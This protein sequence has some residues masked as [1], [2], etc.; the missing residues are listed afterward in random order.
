MSQSSKYPFDTML[1]IFC[2]IAGASSHMISNASRIT[3]NHLS[4]QRYRTS[5]IDLI[6]D[7][8][9]AEILSTS[10]IDLSDTPTST[11][12]LKIHVDPKVNMSVT[13]RKNS[14][15]CPLLGNILKGT[16]M[17]FCRK[18]EDILKLILPQVM[19]LTKTE[20]RRITADLRWTCPSLEPFL[21][22]SSSLGWYLI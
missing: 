3:Q 17:I 10:N 11:D 18:H 1:V 22:R 8:R 4:H 13:Q 9:L 6:L 21:D 20:C 12:H 7:Q 16:Q 2:V 19:K 15:I 14:H 5:I